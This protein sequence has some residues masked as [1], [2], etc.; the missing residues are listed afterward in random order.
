MSSTDL[1]FINNNSI[2]LPIE[3]APGANEEQKVNK[4]DFEKYSSFIHDKVNCL[5]ISKHHHVF[6]RRDPNDF[7]S[8]FVVS[9]QWDD[10]QGNKGSHQFIHVYCGMD[11]VENLSLVSGSKV[12]LEVGISRILLDVEG[13]FNHPLFNSYYNDNHPKVIAFKQAV[14]ALL[15]IGDEALKM[16]E[17]KLPW[18]GQIWTPREVSG[19]PEKMFFLLPGGKV[20]K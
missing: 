15:K 3:S 5:S 6:Q 4:K 14:D 20:G 16:V 12:K 18:D 19:H 8:P 10:S 11:T 7:L 1:S 17:I 2:Y 13:I 9:N